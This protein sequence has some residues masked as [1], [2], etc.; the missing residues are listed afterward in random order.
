MSSVVVHTALPAEDGAYLTPAH[1]D[2]LM[3]TTCAMMVDITVNKASPQL[4]RCIYRQLLAFARIVAESGAQLSPYVQKAMRVIIREA[5][6]F[7]AKQ[8]DANLVRLLT[9][10]MSEP[11]W[12]QFAGLPDP[13]L[14]PV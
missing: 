5:H 2:E 6:Q 9:E 4:V 12:R 1:L 7:L 3:Q 14:T 11:V 8:S 10:M 13:T